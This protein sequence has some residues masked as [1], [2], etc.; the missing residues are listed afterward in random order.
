M[1]ITYYYIEK[2]VYIYIFRSRFSSCH[3]SENKYFQGH[4]RS[5]Y[6]EYS[7]ENAVVSIT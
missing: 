7:N 5:E 6:K 3:T 4:Y 2:Y 1:C